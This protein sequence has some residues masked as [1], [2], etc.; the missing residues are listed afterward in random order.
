MN[1]SP[2]Q[3]CKTLYKTEPCRSFE[4]TGT[5]RYGSKC[6]FAHGCEDIRP[7][8]RHPK[9][10]TELCRTFHTIGTCPYGTRC[11]FIHTT[12][13]YVLEDELFMEDCS[14]SRS[15]QRLPVF[16]VVCSP[17]AQQDENSQQQ[18]QQH[19]QQQQQHYPMTF[20]P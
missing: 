9:Y 20:Y 7:V 18:Q 17:H 19:Q 10:K 12:D 15:R 8:L 11:R 4:E 16:Q 14:N 5:C 2:P 3:S 6:Q 1:K 13:T